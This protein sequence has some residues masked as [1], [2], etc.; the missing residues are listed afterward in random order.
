MVL[1]GWTSTTEAIKVG[2][3]KF[4][5]KDVRETIA[6][7]A[8]PGDP[9]AIDAATGEPALSRR[10]WQQWT[11]ELELSEDRKAKVIA[12]MN[13]EHERCRGEEPAPAAKRPRSK[14]EG[15]GWMGPSG[16]PS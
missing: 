14:V 12:R 2:C 1:G 9:E 10:Q 7:A 16:G 15:P 6:R 11:D 13:A 8:G 4:A 5:R 3:P